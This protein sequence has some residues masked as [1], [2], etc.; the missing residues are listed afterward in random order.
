[1]DTYMNLN[2]PSTSL[3]QEKP[4]YTN[5]VNGYG[6]FSSRVAKTKTNLILTPLTQDTLSRGQFSCYMR[7][8]DR[9][10]VVWGCQ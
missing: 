3:V 6:V 10:N 5:I 1:L 2:G 8:G 7:F 9:N 4:F